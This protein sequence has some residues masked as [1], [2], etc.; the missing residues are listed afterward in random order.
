MQKKCS[1]AENIWHFAVY[2]AFFCCS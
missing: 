2:M 1:N